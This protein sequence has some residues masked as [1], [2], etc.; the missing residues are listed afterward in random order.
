VL[1]LEVVRVAEDYIEFR[2]EGETHTL[3][4]PLVEYLS[5][6][7]EVEYVTYD[8]DHPLLERVTFRLKTRGSN[9]LEV[10]RRVVERILRDLEEL[11]RQMVGGSR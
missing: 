1:K 7:P 5:M 8:V 3:F 10:V 9:P 11:E 4:S 6:D 2:A